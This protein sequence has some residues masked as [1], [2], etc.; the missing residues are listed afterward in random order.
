MATKNQKDYYYLRLDDS[1]IK[2][3]IKFIDYQY[4]TYVS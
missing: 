4:P 2:A 1:I 3:T